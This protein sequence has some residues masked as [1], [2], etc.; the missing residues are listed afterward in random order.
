VNSL[1]SSCEVNLYNENQCCGIVRLS[2]LG[3]QPSLQYCEELC[4]Q[5]PAA[6]PAH[7]KVMF[8]RPE[9]NTVA[10]P[11]NRQW[12]NRLPHTSSN[13]M[14]CLGKLART[15]SLGTVAGTLQAN[16]VQGPANASGSL[17]DHGDRCLHGMMWVGGH[18]TPY[19]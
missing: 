18:L 15:L 3:I 1:L 11:F 14:D 8:S 10:L 12:A 4:G 13:R 9:F 2:L 5:G 17:L 19:G 6:W 7:C 16:Y